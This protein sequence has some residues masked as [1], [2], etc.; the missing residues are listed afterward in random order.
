MFRKCVWKKGKRKKKIPLKIRWGGC[1]L[2]GPVDAGFQKR[3]GCFPGSLASSSGPR[4]NLEI[5]QCLWLTHLRMTSGRLVSKCLTWHKSGQSP[6]GKPWWAATFPQTWAI[7]T[8]ELGDILGNQTAGYSFVSKHQGGWPE[9]QQSMRKGDNVI[10]KFHP[11]GPWGFRPWW[12]I[13]T[14]GTESLTQKE[15]SHPPSLQKEIF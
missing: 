6:L 10:C 5:T 4:L 12:E 2:L 11:T 13:T 15:P 3:P 1:W 8:T 7:A 9:P 14:G